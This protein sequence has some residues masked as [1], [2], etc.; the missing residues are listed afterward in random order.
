MSEDEVSRRLDRLEGRT[1]ERRE[2][3]L[4]SIGV[5]DEIR[6]PHQFPRPPNRFVEVCPMTG[7]RIY[8]SRRDLADTEFVYFRSSGPAGTRH[9]VEL[10]RV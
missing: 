9:V 2:L 5:D 6:Q 4:V 7:E 10:W 8:Q 3:E 1:Q